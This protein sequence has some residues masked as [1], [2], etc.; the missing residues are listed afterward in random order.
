MGFFL[1]FNWTT[2]DEQELTNSLN[3]PQEDEQC[4]AA[5]VRSMGMGGGGQL[6]GQ[7]QGAILRWKRETS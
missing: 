7:L 4:Y 2:L 5:Y 6:E 1:P 3:S